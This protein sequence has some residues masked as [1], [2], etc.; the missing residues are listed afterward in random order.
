MYCDELKFSSHRNPRLS[1]HLSDKVTIFQTVNKQTLTIL[2]AAKPRNRSLSHVLS[3]NLVFPSV[4]SCLLFSFADC[5]CSYHIRWS[6]CPISFLPR[7]LTLVP[8]LLLL[9]PKGSPLLSCQE[10]A[11]W[12]PHWVTC[13]LDQTCSTWWRI[14]GSP[15][16]RGSGY[17]YSTL[18]LHRVLLRHRSLEWKPYSWLN[19]LRAATAAVVN[20]DA[21]Q[22][23]ASFATG[24]RIVLLS[25]VLEISLQCV[26]GW[27]PHL[28]PSP[29]VLGETLVSWD[30]CLQFWKTVCFI[31]DNF[32][33]LILLIWGYG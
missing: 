3:W 25:L 2:L 1:L 21:N 29:V 31:C 12:G 22:I 6:T 11:S 27:P 30:S 24:C 18:A 13:A 8:S 17:H 7:D 32:L 23:P 20:F 15:H 4:H 14:R 26:Q 16:S 9:Q 28:L 10:G 5:L 19:C 33:P